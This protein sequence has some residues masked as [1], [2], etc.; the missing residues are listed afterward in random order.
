MQRHAIDGEFKLLEN[1]KIEF[2]DRVRADLAELE[3]RKK[4]LSSERAALKAEQRKFT[5]AKK[6]LDID[7][8]LDASKHPSLMGN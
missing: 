1:K 4:E 8:K 6:A 2:E 7:S 5:A 3:S